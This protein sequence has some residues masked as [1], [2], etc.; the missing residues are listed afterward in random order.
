MRAIGQSCRRSSVADQSG[1][2]SLIVSVMFLRALTR[3]QC[4]YMLRVLVQCL[5]RLLEAREWGS[6]LDCLAVF[7]VGDCRTPAI[8]TSLNVDL[9]SLGQFLEDSHLGLRGHGSMLPCYGCCVEG[10]FASYKLR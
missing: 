8:R 9:C 4:R 10:H 5:C 3:F 7:A 6:R 1:R 2:W